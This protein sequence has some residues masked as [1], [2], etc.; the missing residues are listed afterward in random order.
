MNRGR[1]LP[2]F[3]RYLDDLLGD[4]RYTSRRLLVGGIR[5]GVKGGGLGPLPLP[6]YLILCVRHIVSGDQIHTEK[7]KM[8]AL[9]SKE[10]TSTNFKFTRFEMVTG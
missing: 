3:F 2:L 6:L 5:R 4:I 7:I 1:G 9:V 10:P 8:H